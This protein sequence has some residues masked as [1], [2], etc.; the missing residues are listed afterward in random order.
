MAILNTV[1]D[2]IVYTP[3]VII[4]L[5]V[6]YGIGYGIWYYKRN[7][8]LPPSY[9]KALDIIKFI[10]IKLLTPIKWLG[11][12]LWW[13]IPIFPDRFR[14]DVFGYIPMGAWARNNITRTGLITL[15]VS[16]FTTMILINKYGLPDTVIGYSSTINS[17]LIILAALTIF[18]MFIS[19]NYKIM[20]SGNGP[21]GAWPT[22]D[23]GTLDSARRNWVW[24][25]SKTYLYYAIAV[26]LALALLTLLFYLVVNY[27]MFNVAAS[28]MVS[29]L[30]GLGA[31]FL[32]YKMASRNR[33]VQSALRKSKFLSGLFYLVFIIPCLFQDT[34]KFIFNQVRHTP[35]VAYAFLTAEMLL[36][37][38]YLVIPIV[39]KYLYTVMP[40]KDDKL[41]IIKTKIESIKKQKIILK[42]RIEN[43]ENF[44]A[45][46][47]KGF[48]FLGKSKQATTSSDIELPTGRK[49]DKK[50]WRNIIS[51]GLNNPKNDEQLQ[52]LLSNY[53][54]TTKDM[55][56]IEISKEERQ[57]CSDRI[58]KAIKYIQ[59]NTLELIGLKGKLKEA[60][61]MLKS[62]NEEASRISILERSK[63]LLSDPIYLKNKRVLS[64]FDVEKVD[65]FDIEYN[66][67]YALSSWFFIRAQSPEYGKAYNTY[68]PILD[69]GGKPTILYNG[70]LNRLKIEMNNG[71]DNK[72]K[73]FL[74]NDFPLQKW[75]NIVV[76]YDGG[77][78]DVFMNSK[79]LASFNNIVPYMSQDQISVGDL[80][81][82]GGGVCNVVYFPQ[83]ISKERIDINYNILSKKNPPV[84]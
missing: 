64:S 55:C 21:G 77:I 52:Q 16:I 67:N 40:Q 60:N 19:F 72:P 44:G 70:R 23:D 5:T 68:T 2:I 4:S 43:I 7:S 26:G 38:L 32:I 3:L 83:S 80:D 79:L 33:D 63:V 24:V 39:K 30:A 76:N 45:V 28:T 65:N 50:G 18:T 57:E 74:I 20:S 6:L 73:T 11:Q 62:L 14:R 8:S 29:V 51:N 75:T 71:L 25:T 31:M 34:V 13:L 10:I 53:G 12:F 61:S 56:S 36:I 35:K 41:L 1:A 78:L 15:L 17:T 84:I 49:I 22:N 27:T 46:Q 42:K 81:G 82:I 47:Q 58:Q 59:N 66:Y 9:E 69:Y 37:G 48:K 54:Y